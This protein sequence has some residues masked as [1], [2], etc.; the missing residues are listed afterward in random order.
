MRVIQLSVGQPAP[1]EYRGKPV[2]T[3]IYKQPVEGPLRVAFHGITGDGQGD[4]VHHGGPD[5][6]VCAYPSEHYAYWASWLGRPPG[7]AAFGE[8]VTT[9]GLLETEVCIGDLYEVGTA[10]LQVSQPRYP[11]FKLSLKHGPAE[12]PARVLETGYS[13]FYFR[14]LREGEIAANSAIVKVARGE[15]G[16]TVRRVLRA[17]EVGRRDPSGLEELAALTALSEGIRRDFGEWMGRA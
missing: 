11:C 15:G 3:G 10:L 8:N 4:L 12:F 14:V 7:S 6:A 9:E 16:V 17:M 13:G 1:V 2:E 5:K